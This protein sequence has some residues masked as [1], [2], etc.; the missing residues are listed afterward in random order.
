MLV[1][2][3]GCERKHEWD[4]NPIIGEWEAMNWALIRE[5]D[6]E[7]VYERYV[8]KDEFLG[9]KH[10]FRRDGSGAV[11]SNFRQDGKD[12]WQT[13]ESF[14]WTLS[15]DKLTFTDKRFISPPG[16]TIDRNV[17]SPFFMETDWTIHKL[18]Y[19]EL[20]VS[21]SVIPRYPEAISLGLCPDMKEHN[22]LTFRK[23][24]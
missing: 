23:V 6:G 4:S 16:M 24:R 9:T 19:E 5:T 2:I 13:I 1:M 15:D 21:F 17:L 20:D 3:V 12:N 10:I 11:I 22:T 7:V 8:D 18:S 14:T